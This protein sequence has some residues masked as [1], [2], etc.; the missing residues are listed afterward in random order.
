M[1]LDKLV[2][3]AMFVLAVVGVLMLSVLFYIQLF[4]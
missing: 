4:C 3:R 1:N 2:Q